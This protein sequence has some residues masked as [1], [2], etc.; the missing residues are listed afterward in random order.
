MPGRSRRISAPKNLCAQRVLQKNRILAAILLFY[1]SMQAFL[2]QIVR[3]LGCILA[4]S[5][6]RNVF[7]KRA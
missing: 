1:L 6:L 5:I 3:V 2:S 4:F 7:S